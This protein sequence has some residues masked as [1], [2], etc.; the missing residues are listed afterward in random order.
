MIIYFPQI[1]ALQN[2]GYI[3]LTEDKCPI[4]IDDIFNEYVITWHTPSG[5]EFKFHHISNKV[6]R[7]EG[8]TLFLE[9]EEGDQMTIHSYYPKAIFEY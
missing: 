8:N 7:I 3:F 9:N 4:I 2:D 6:I 5:E 1:V